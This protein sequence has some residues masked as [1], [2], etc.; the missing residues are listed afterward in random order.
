M[1]TKTGIVKDSAFT[2]RN[3][4]IVAV[5]VSAVTGGNLLLHLGGPPVGYGRYADFGF[6]L[7]YSL[8]K[9][10]T[11]SGFGWEPTESG[12]I[13]TVALPGMGLDQ[14]GVIWNAPEDM[15]TSMRSLEGALGYI[16]GLIGMEGTVVANVGNPVSMTKN[17]HEMIYKTWNLME[18]GF[19][20][21]GIIGTWYCEDAGK[22]LSF[23]LVYLPDPANPTVDPQELEQVWLGYLDQVTCKLR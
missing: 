5:I 21:P 20:V 7:D 16:F 1:E 23:Y 12:G 14:Y 8:R 9:E 15:P 3:L 2:P 6:T 4:L 19:A 10:I 17:G 18:S 22:Y 13:V 11:V